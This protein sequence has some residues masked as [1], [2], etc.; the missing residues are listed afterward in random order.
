MLVEVVFMLVILKIPVIYLC[1]VVWWAIRAEPRPPEGALNAAR[2]PDPDPCSW[3]RRRRAPTRT[4]PC[5]G[6]RRAAPVLRARVA[7]R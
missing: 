4:S 5:S 1:A 6:S 2:L 3:S 7:R